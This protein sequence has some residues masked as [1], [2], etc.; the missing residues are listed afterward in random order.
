[1]CG[2]DEALADWRGDFLGI[3]VVGLKCDTCGEPFP[4]PTFDEAIAHAVE[5][6]V[7]AKRARAAL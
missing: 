5:A 7:L 6:Q 1:M 3:E 4:N 2:K